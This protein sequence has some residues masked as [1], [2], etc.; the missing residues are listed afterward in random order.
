MR[1]VLPRYRWVWMCPEPMRGVSRVLGVRP[2][3]LTPSR[4]RVCRRKVGTKVDTLWVLTLPCW[5]CILESSAREME[6]MRDMFNQT[7]N[8]IDHLIDADRHISRSDFVI[9]DGFVVPTWQIREG[10]E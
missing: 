6:G 1:G 4:V 10:G 2:S 3:W 8:T 7:Q 5:G 9:V